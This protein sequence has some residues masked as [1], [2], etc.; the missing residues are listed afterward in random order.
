[1]FIAKDVAKALFATDAD[2]VFNQYCKHVVQVPNTVY[3]KR[4]INAIGISDVGRLSIKSK[5]QFSI[6]FHDWI[7]EEVLPTLR[8]TSF[9]KQDDTANH[10]KAGNNNR[11]EQVRNNEQIIK[12]YFDKK[13]WRI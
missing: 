6:D 5:S 9:D 13:L 12:D 7:Y 4:K 10:G 11:Q 3:P 1:M 2:R 8:G